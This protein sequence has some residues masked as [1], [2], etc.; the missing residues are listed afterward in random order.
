MILKQ[1]ISWIVIT[2]QKDIAIIKSCGLGSGAV[3]TLFVTFGLIIGLLGSGLG[4]LTGYYITKNV[5]QIEQW[6]NIVFGMKLWKSSTYM[7]SRI[8]NQV[9]WHWAAWIAIAAVLAACIGTLIPALTASKLKPVKILRY[10]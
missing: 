6:I 9:D 7:F 10:E 5:N 1:I 4:I 2:K 3:T 8:P